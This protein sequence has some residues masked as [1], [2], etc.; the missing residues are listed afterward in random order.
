MELTA[1]P[2]ELLCFISALRAI[3]ESSAKLPL[4]LRVSKRNT[5]WVWQKLVIEHYKC[6]R[7]PNSHHP[8]ISSAVWHE[9]V[10]KSRLF[11][12]SPQS[13]A[14]PGINPIWTTGTLRHNLNSVPVLLR[15]KP[16][17]H[18]DYVPS[19]LKRPLC[20]SVSISVWFSWFGMVTVQEKAKRKKTE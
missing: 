19:S 13:P 17:S 9:G 12:S 5:C 1:V 4:T 15:F 14:L 7:L 8:I 2:F 6:S 10:L 16:T 20:H 3:K 11:T 18:S